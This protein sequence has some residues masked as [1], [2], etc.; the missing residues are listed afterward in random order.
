MDLEESWGKD[1]L[2]KEYQETRMKEKKFQPFA[3]A[4]QNYCLEEAEALWHFIF[5]IKTSFGTQG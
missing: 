5:T 3:H 1:Q 4:F 2:K